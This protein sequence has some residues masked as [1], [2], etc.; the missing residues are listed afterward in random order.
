MTMDRLIEQKRD[1]HALTKSEIRFFIDG[2]TA[3]EIPDYQ[4]AALLMAIYFQGMNRAET[5]NLTRAM[6]ESGDM[7]DLSE[8]CEYAIDKHSSGGVGDKT[9]LV[10]LPLVASFGVP[11]AKMSGR[12]LGP[13]GGTIDKLESISGF[14]VNLSEAEFRRIA[15]ECGIV[16]AGQTKSLAP[17]DGAIYAL[18]DVTGTVASRPLIASSIMSKKLA[19][20]ASGI[21]L[22][23][24]VG[25]GAFMKTLDEARAL[26]R[27]MVQIGVDAG[28][29]M[30][31]LLSD[32][33]QP[34]GVAVGNALEVAEA[35]KTLQGEGPADFHQH[36]VEVAAQMLR[37]AGRGERW[38]ELA[39]A[40]AEVDQV[41][42]SGAAFEHLH[43][44]VKAQ[45]GDVSQIE[46]IRKLPQAKLR[47]NVHARQSGAIAA[48]LA[49]RVAWATL[50]LG[51]GRR[52]KDDE[53]D[54]AVG[55]EVFGSVGDAVAVGDLLMTV[56]ANNEGSLQT[57]LEELGGA[58]G[59]SA[60]AVEPLPL[61]HGVVD[62]R[63]F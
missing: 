37:L 59:Y 16:I 60:S 45:G 42:K 48:I 17:A 51:A 47:Y 19:A 55:I 25:R 32:V 31:A 39:D 2:Y 26:A 34:L 12:G 27:T 14:N 36:C 49:D 5:V 41:L 4:V 9:S 38:A 62:G 58:V 18:R 28:R 13:T 54:H 21:V 20:G 35:V 57:A 56:H 6:A 15:R 43:R 10:A 50:A 8:I 63:K 24:K 3:G 22:D 23:V 44:M 53:I 33:N 40:R 29:D 46:D 52:T 7:L 1:G 11:I 61:F 30:V